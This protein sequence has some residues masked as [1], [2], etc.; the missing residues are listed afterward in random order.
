MSGRRAGSSSPLAQR[1][2]R[3]GFV[4]ECLSG[5]PGVWSV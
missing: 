2:V 5:A 4:D 3:L 1:F